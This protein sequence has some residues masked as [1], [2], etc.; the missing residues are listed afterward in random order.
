LVPLPEYAQ[1]F[2]DDAPFGEGGLVDVLLQR[3]RET[4]QLDVKRNDF[5]LD[6]LAP[7][8]FMN[9]RV[10]DEHGRQLGMGRNLAALK[11]E[12]GGLARSAFQALAGL[13][14]RAAEPSPQP[15]RASGRGSKTEQAVRQEL[16][17]PAAGDGRGEGP[18]HYTS[19][20]FGSLPELMEIRRGNQTLIGFPALIDRNMHVEIE[21]FDEPEIAASKHRAGLRR[22]VS[23]QIKEPLKYL[24]KNIPDLQKMAV[25]FMPLGTADELRQQ[26]IDVALDR[27]LLQEPLPTDEASFKTRIDE[28]RTRLNLIAQEVA[29]LAGGILSEYGATTRKLKDARPQKEVADD[30]QAQLQRLMPKRFLAVIPYAQLQ[31]YPR[32]LK[33]IQMR[34]DKLR[35]DPGRD[36][37]RMAELRPLEQRCLRRLADMKGAS[38]ARLDEYRWLLEELRVS[39][40]AQELRTPQ[41]VSVKRLDKAWAQVCA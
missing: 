15:F 35:T 9:F 41:P 14:V 3:V 24:E 17:L 38:D 31:H 13:K 23:L 29:R 18:P 11:A 8:Q 16:P 33:A 10:V 30:I 39:L 20:T 12:L 27:A 4:T 32:Y 5:K 1:A 37:Q 21:V 40:F 6:A 22:L 26:I 2:V 25:A 19:W 7:H 36:I 34:L 28:G